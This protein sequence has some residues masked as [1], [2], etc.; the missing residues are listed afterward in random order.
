MTLPDRVREALD[1]FDRLEP[2][3][4]PATVAAA[5][6]TTAQGIPAELAALYERTRQLHL[7]G[8]GYLYDLGDHVAVN[9]RPELQAAFPGASFIG[10]DGAN[11][12][13]FI[14]RAG[15]LGGPAGAVYLADGS[16]LWAAH[17]IAAGADLAAFLTGCAAGSIPWVGPS[18]EAARID[19]M[20]DSLGR[21]E[22]GWDGFPGIAELDMLVRKQNAEIRALYPTRS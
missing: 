14:D 19:R 20:R 8:G 6:E 22:D 2:P 9:Q 18:L 13:L 4:E 12:L 3:P 1:R 11:G 16:T 17:C 15:A 21:H 5:M 10:D 7:P